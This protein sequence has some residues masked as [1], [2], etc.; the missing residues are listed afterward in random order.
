[1]L[2]Y[3]LCKQRYS[4]TVLSGDGG[5]HADGR[6]HT[7]GK[8]VVYCASSESLAVLELRVHVGNWLPCDRFAMH[9]IEVPD[10]HVNLLK[11]ESLPEDWNVVPFS[12]V[13]QQLGNAWLSQQASPALRV[14]S[15]HTSTEFNVLLNPLHGKHKDVKV[16]RVWQYRF[17]ARLFAA[18]KS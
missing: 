18:P 5:L 8:P 6:W 10:R 13:S 12:G 3:R 7:V 16:K 1:M 14:P 4:A 9:E 11:L 2:I 15:I 17:D